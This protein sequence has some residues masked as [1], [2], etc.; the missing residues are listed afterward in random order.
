M[1]ALEYIRTLWPI[2]IVLLPFVCATGFIWLKTQFPT[3][4]DLKGTEQRITDRI[5]EHEERLDTGSRTMATLDKR[6]ALVEE[7]CRQAPSRQT[8]Q[9]E[10]SAISQRTRGVEVEVQAVG[11]ELS[12]L[13]SYLHTLIERGI[14]GSAHR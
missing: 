14:T 13:N 11:R 4:A 6:T 2:A 9:G 1:S 3:L 12:T 10:L 7:E 5:E 8:L